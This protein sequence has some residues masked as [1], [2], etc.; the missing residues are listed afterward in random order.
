MAEDDDILRIDEALSPHIGDN[1]LHLGGGQPRRREIIAGVAAAGDVADVA[2]RIAIAAPHRHRHGEA[3]VDEPL[4][5]QDVVGAHRAGH[6]FAAARL[7]VVDRDQRKRAVGGR[8]IYHCL[9]QEE[10]GAGRRGRDR[11]PPLLPIVWTQRRTCRPGLRTVYGASG[12]GCQQQQEGHQPC[13]HSK[14][15]R[16]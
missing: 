14:M 15:R 13:R 1:A 11:D 2:L 7:A 4:R 5:R 8:P 9:Q 16:T 3:T 10:V 6:Q 12:G